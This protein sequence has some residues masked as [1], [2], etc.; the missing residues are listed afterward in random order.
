M[1]VPQPQLPD[2]PREVPPYEG[3]QIGS[4]EDS[5]ANCLN[6]IPK[7]PKRDFI[8][9]MEKDR[10][11][12]RMHCTCTLCVCTY[13][14]TNSV[15]LCCCNTRMYLRTYICMYVCMFRNLPL[16]RAYV[17]WFHIFPCG[18]H[19]LT[20]F[21]LVIPTHL[22]PCCRH[23]LDSNV[24]RFV[25]CLDTTK[26]IDMDRRFIVSFFLSDDTISIHEPPQ[27]NSG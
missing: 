18:D 22:C 3:F 15:N 7:P 10:L 12:I 16:H 4:E 8:K 5:L 2:I 25:A 14:Q 26:P 9:F 17:L 24:L 11:G 21:W 20:A 27:R 13:V 23:G 1:D 6:L 19:P